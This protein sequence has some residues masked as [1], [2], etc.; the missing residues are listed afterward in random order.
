VVGL[1]S[2]P[3]GITVSGAVLTGTLGT[4]MPAVLLKRIPPEYR[5]AVISSFIDHATRADVSRDTRGIVPGIENVGDGPALM[6][7]ALTLDAEANQSGDAE[8]LDA[9]SQDAERAR[10][11]AAHRRIR[12]E[13]FGG[14]NR[15]DD[16][17]LGLPP[18]QR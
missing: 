6:Q 17:T 12:D 3:S 5:D 4:N 2:R 13:Q 15:F 11:L 7:E 9:F 18:P 14:T 16:K 1:E 8:L 10:F